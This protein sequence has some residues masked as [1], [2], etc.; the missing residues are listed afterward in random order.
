MKRGGEG[1]GGGVRGAYLREE[2][3]SWIDTTIFQFRNL[4]NCESADLH[5][6]PL[7]RSMCSA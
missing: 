4:L 7:S 6:D 3:K 5:Y 2:A 1:G